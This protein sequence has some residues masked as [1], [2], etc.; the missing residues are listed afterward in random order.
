[1]YLWQLP[2]DS[3]SMKTNYLAEKDDIRTIPVKVHKVTT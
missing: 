3:V 2:I 1:M